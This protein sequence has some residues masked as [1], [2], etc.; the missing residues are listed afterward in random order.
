MKIFT[1]IFVATIIALSTF[2]TPAV[3]STPLDVNILSDMSNWPG[4]TFESS[5]PAMESGLICKDGIVNDVAATSAGG[6]SSIL[7]L[8]VHKHFVCN[9]ES[10]SFEMDLIVRIAPSQTTGRWLVVAGSGNYEGLSGEGVVYATYSDSGGVLDT[11]A[12]RLIM[13]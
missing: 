10:G 12:G 7:I 5:G 4:G 2:I 6:N 13:H 9:D 8:F 11:Y 1:S 3:A